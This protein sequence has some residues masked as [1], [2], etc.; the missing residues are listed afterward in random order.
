MKLHHRCHIKINSLEVKYISLL[1][2][3]KESDL[4][5]ELLA[6]VSY[7]KS[8]LKEKKY[9]QRTFTKKLILTGNGNSVQ[10]NYVFYR[11]WWKDTDEWKNTIYAVSITMRDKDKKNKIK[12]FAPCHVDQAINNVLEKKLLEI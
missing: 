5:N 3:V 2:K 7:F 6:K 4:L 9:E 8:D 11:N 1:L 10:I 12:T